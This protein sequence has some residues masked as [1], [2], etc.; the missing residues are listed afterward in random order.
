MM[1]SAVVAIE[2]RKVPDMDVDC[3]ITTSTA[4][5]IRTLTL[6]Q[7]QSMGFMYETLV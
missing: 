4:I 6:V 2:R 5:H 3:G 7:A 1:F